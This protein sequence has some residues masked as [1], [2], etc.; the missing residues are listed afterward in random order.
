MEAVKGEPV[1]RDYE[2]SRKSIDQH[3]AQGYQVTTKQLQ[4]RKPRA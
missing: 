1:S 3:I 4:R 2:F